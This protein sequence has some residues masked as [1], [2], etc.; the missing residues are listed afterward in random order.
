MRTGQPLKKPAEKKTVEKKIKENLCS[1]QVQAPVAHPTRRGIHSERNK[2]KILVSGVGL[3]WLPSHVIFNNS[4]LPQITNIFNFQSNTH[5]YITRLSSRGNYFV[6]YSRLEKQNTTFS[7]V[8][9]KVW[10][11]LPVKMHHTSQRILNAKS[12]LLQKLLEADDHTNLP[13]L[14]KNWKYFENPVYYIC[15]IHPTLVNII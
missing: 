14:I 11:S 13:D 7:H 5:P 8:G 9:V 4:S 1:N 3:E 15:I 2:F 6:Q 12:V 10:N